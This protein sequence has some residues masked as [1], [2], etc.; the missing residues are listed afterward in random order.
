MFVRE[1]LQIKGS[2]VFTIPSSANLSDVVTELTAHN[3]GSLVVCD[4][5]QMIGI[6]TERDI[7][8]A[9]AGLHDSLKDIP[10]RP[11]MSR[12]VITASPM[13][14]VGDVMGIM[15][16]HRVR[17]LPVLEAGELAGL[18]SIG[19]VVKAQHAELTTENQLLK[20]YIQS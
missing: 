11:L 12:D 17:H 8:R 5:D 15:T 13:D 14:K 10:L 3:C 16:E 1:I 7:L 18:I 9:C 2:R 6:I 19:D 4:G 20:E